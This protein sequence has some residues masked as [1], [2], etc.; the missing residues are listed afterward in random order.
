MQYVYNMQNASG[1]LSSTCQTSHAPDSWKCI[2]APYAAPFITTPW[3]AFQSRFD[4]WQLSEV[5]YY[6]KRRRAPSLD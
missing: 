1:S 4:K 5:C 6:L 2:M 3:F